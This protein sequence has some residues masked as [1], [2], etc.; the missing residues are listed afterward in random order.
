M[1]TFQFT[2]RQNYND[3]IIDFPL[4]ADET[5]RFPYHPDEEQLIL[6]NK[7]ADKTMKNPITTE[8]L[9]ERYRAIEKEGNHYPKYTTID[10]VAQLIKALKE[11]RDYYDSWKANI[12]MAFQD[13]YN[14]DEC[15]GIRDSNIHYHSNKAADNFLKQLIR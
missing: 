3:F 13:Q 11:D 1:K 15:I 14:S 4:D 9:K 12:A 6:L 8:Q 2:G 7:L 5:L 10:A